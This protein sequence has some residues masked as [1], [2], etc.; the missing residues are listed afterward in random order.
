SHTMKFLAAIT[1]VVFCSPVWAQEKAETDWNFSTAKAK[2]A[3]K[4]YE[5]ATQ[6]LNEKYAEH[7]KQDLETLRSS[8]VTAMKEQ[9]QAGNLD[10]AVKLK[11][12]AAAIAA[13]DEP[14]EAA[15]PAKSA[16]KRRATTKQLV[17]LD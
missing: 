1:T 2:A 8:L 6:K 14:A 5:A 13:G 11:A 17:Y 7:H 16:P 15:T 10:E 3:L 12:A 4:D 9:T